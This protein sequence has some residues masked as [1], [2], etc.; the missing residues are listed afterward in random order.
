MMYLKQLF[1]AIDKWSSGSH[2]PI[3]FREETYKKEYGK[4]LKDVEEWH[5]VDPSLF[6]KDQQQMHNNLR[7]VV[8]FFNLDILSLP[9]LSTQL[10]HSKKEL[11]PIADMDEAD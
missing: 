6:T 5:G 2:K 3:Q 4:Q 1:C 10:G 8:Q 9:D 7:C 11:A